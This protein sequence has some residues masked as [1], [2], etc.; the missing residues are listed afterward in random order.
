IDHTPQVAAKE[1]NETITGSWR[2]GIMSM[3][4][5]TE[6]GEAYMVAF[7]AKKNDAAITRYFTLEYDY[8]LATKSTRTIMCER[9]G[10]RTLKLG[11][12][13]AVTGDFQTD[14]NAFADAIIGIVAPLPKE[15]Y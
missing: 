5:P 4:T 6:M 7:V 13:P 3:P 2:M 1:K 15:R 9:D 12:G 14:S 8:V 11:E 10:T